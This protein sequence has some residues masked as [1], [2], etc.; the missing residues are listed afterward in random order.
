MNATRCDLHLHSAASI[1][2]DEWYTRFFGCPES[3]AEPIMQYE[4]CKSRGMSLVTLTD[5]DTIDGVLQIAERP[6]V[7]V[8]EELTAGFRGEPQAVHVL[9]YGITPDDHDWLRAHR[10][11]EV[12][13]RLRTAEARKLLERWAEDDSSWLGVESRAGLVIFQ[14]PRKTE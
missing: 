9:C 8:S 1:G 6:D 3:Y 14:P 12:L 10:L 5:H 7:F 13:L 11:V 2:N 4:L